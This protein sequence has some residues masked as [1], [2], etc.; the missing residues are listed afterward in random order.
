MLDASKLLVPTP[1]L[2]NA[3][4]TIAKG[5]N[6]DVGVAQGV[7]QSFADAPG[8]SL[9][10][11]HEVYWGTGIEYWYSE[12]FALRFGYF[13]EHESKGGRQYFTI[14]AG[15]SYNVFTLD[16]SYLIPTAGF[17]SPMAN[18]VRFSLMVNFNEPA[19]KGKVKGNVPQVEGEEEAY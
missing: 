17:N 14:G 15:V 8:G 9:E 4:G 10:E 16:A 5:K 7:F 2:Y 12:L 11:F 1:P 6:P 19:K 18:T 3:D 13:Y